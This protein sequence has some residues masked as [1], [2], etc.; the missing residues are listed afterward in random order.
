MHAALDILS[1]YVCAIT[2]LSKFTKPALVKIS[3]PSAMFTHCIW[4]D[5][6]WL[7]IES[8]HCSMLRRPETPLESPQF[9]ACDKRHKMFFPNERTFNLI[10]QSVNTYKTLAEMLLHVKNNSRRK[11]LRHVK[12]NC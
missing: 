2:D 6:R 11:C 8:V 3:C 4:I 5:A 7:S 9:L 10:D 1:K 12:D